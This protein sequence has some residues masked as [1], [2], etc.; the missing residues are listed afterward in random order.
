[1]TPPLDVAFFR[2]DQTTFPYLRSA[3]SIAL[4]AQLEMAR[5]RKVNPHS[6]LLPADTPLK[7]PPSQRSFSS[8]F[9]NA[10]HSKS[11]K[12][13]QNRSEIFFIHILFQRP[14]FCL[15]STPNSDNSSSITS[16][17]LVIPFPSKQSS[18]SSF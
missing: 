9:I 2:P 18:S 3:R 5:L 4:L 15:K 17:C 14:N 8:Q 12:L 11:L 6:E 7:S 1:M 13:N 16:N 10:R